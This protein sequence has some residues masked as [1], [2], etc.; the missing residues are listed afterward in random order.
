M[1][2]VIGDIGD[3]DDDSIDVVDYSVDD[4]DGEK[5]LNKKKII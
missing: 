4:D 2:V 1:T 3:G 5:S